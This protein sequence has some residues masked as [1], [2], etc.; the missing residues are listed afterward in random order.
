[1]AALLAGATR[2]RPSDIDPSALAAAQANAE[3]NGLSLEVSECLP[4]EYDVLLASTCSTS[5]ATET[6]CVR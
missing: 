1:M 4:S 3:L 5:W 2:G 6:F